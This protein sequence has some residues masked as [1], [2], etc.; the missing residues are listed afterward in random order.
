M[1][2]FKFILLFAMAIILNACGTDSKKTTDTT[3]SSSFSFF[4]DSEKTYEF[5]DSKSGL[6]VSTAKY[7]SD[8]EVITKA[9]YKIDPVI[10]AFRYQIKDQAGMQAFNTPLKM[11]YASTNPQ[12]EQMMRNSGLKNVKSLMTP[13]QLVQGEVAPKLQSKGFSFSNSREFPELEQKALK[14]ARKNTTGPME[15]SIN[16]TIWHGNNGQ[17]ALVILNYGKLSQPTANGQTMMV[18]MYSTDVLISN[19]IDFETNV[20]DFVKAN[21]ESEPTTEW[22]NYM[23]QLTTKRQEDNRRQAQASQARMQQSAIAHQQRMAQRQASF[24]AHQQKMAGISASMDASHASF[25]NNNFGSESSTSQQNF[26]NMIHGEE[27]VYNPGNGN[28]YQIESGAKETWMDNNGNA[29]YSDDLFFDPNANNSL[30]NTEWSKVW[31]DY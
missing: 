12:F 27:T 29:I 26:V 25:M 13:Q 24:N 1:K 15:I 31:E 16:G 21:L 6:L 7:P 30:N 17:K 4:G 14:E 9:E 28:S 18:W 10:P 2:T 5:K 22:D 23:A 11:H 19:E 8:W 3:S 20:A